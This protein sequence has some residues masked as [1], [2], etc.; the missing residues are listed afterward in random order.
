MYF[1][2]L[3]VQRVH[4]WV[5]KRILSKGVFLVIPISLGNQLLMAELWAH[6]VVGGGD[7]EIGDVFMG[8]LRAVGFS[9]NTLLPSG[10]YLE[11]ESLVFLV[12]SFRVD[13]PY[14]LHFIDKILTIINHNLHK[15][16]LRRHQTPPF[17]ATVSLNAAFNAITFWWFRMTKRL[18][19]WVEWLKLNIES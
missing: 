7:M 8:S 14:L 12:G 11:W 9:I 16:Q 2:L 6:L 1:L 10:R 19:L 4:I 13:G 15:L 18:K 5:R 17:H 3:N